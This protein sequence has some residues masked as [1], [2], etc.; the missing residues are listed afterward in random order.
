MTYKYRCER[1]FYETNNYTNVIK[2]L[3]KK[4]KCSKNLIS[5]SHSDDQIFILSILPR[6]ISIKEN[7]LKKYEKT[8]LLY[9][10]KDEIINMFTEIHCDCIKKCQYCSKEF[11]KLDD[12]K[13]HILLTCYTINHV[14]NIN[15]ITN[16]NNSTNNI[17]N[18]TNNITNNIS[19]ININLEIKYPIPF[20]EDWDLSQISKDGRLNDLFQKSVYTNLLDKILKNDNNMNVIIEDTNNEKGLVYQNNIDKYTEIDI[21]DIVEK[22]MEK[23]KKHLLQLSCDK[24]FLSDNNF[25]DIIKNAIN[26]NILTIRKKYNDYKF[27]NNNVKPQVNE[28]IKFVYNQNKENAIKKL[29]DLQENTDK[30][31]Y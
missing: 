20:N 10:N 14:T 6:D 1:C 21:E 30:Y 3:N 9:Q 27:N 25:N 22:T 5:Y 16:N 12:L 8:S 13:K 28:S 11:P 7:E 29:N 24:T 18:S 4:K 31:G 23:L 2:H 15:I 19:N 26:D 17:D